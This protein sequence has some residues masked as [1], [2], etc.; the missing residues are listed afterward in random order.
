MDGKGSR[1]SPHARRTA[2]YRLPN[3]LRLL[4]PAKELALSV[5]GPYQFLDLDLGVILVIRTTQRLFSSF[6]S[7]RML[8]TVERPANVAIQCVGIQVETIGNLF[9]QRSQ[10]RPKASD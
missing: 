9:D 2:V 4:D 1:G 7:D 10:E 3:A 6:I 5:D 8:H